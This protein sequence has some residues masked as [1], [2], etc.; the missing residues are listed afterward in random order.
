MPILLP[1][2]RDLIEDRADKDIMDVLT[3]ASP[4]DI[5]EVFDS[6]S[7]PEMMYVFN[8]LPFEL[9]IDVF[10]Q[11]DEE[12]ENQILEVIDRKKKIAI[13]N[14]MASDERADLFEKL[15]EKHKKYYLSIMEK[16]EAEDVKELLSYPPDTAGGLMTTDYVAIYEWMNIGD[17]AKE[18]RETAKDVDFVYDIYVLNRHERPIGFITMRDLIMHKPE[19]PI[20]K[21][22][23]GGVVKTQID[24]NQERV[25]ALFSKY[26]VATMPVVDKK[27]VIKGVITVDDVIDVIEEEDTEDMYHFGA[28]GNPP[29]SYFSAGIFGTAKRRMSWL[30]ILVFAGF[31]SSLV[32]ERYS[33]TLQAML[34]L[35]AFI[36]V[37]MDSGGNAGTQ[38]AA[39]VIRGIAVGDIDFKDIWRVVGRE[40]LVGALVGVGLGS[41]T[42]LRAIL[43]GEGGLIGFI[44][45]LTMIISVAVAT[46]LGGFLPLIFKKLKWDPALMSGPFVTTIVDVTSLGIYFEIARRMLTLIR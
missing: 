28:A 27:G 32:I 11:L 20:G 37:L 12:K 14:R 46:T 33:S 4:Q 44:V 30:L 34:I 6:L 35:A 3:E 17:A 9:A 15:D 19:E 29:D 45:G 25:A 26:D 18:I 39:V 24:C 16:E 1:G 31:L 38:A 36:P 40:F 42:A 21:I 8:L 10:E 23:K 2:I 13:L 22:M 5:A 41:L 7:A 43:M